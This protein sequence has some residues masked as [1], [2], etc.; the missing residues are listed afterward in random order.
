ML[1]YFLAAPL[2]R[3]CRRSRVHG[4]NGV[5]SMTTVYTAGHGNRPLEEFIGLLRDAGVTCLV[6]VRAFPASRRH[7][8]FGRAALEQSLPAAGLRSVW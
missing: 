4:P 1:G 8:H 3:S 6:D 5:F 7:P 2:S